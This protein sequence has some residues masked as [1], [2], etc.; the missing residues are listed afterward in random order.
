MPISTY[1]GVAGRNCLCLLTCESMDASAHG[2][3]GALAQHLMKR[4]LT[5]ERF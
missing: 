4:N 1:A 2:A 5:G 3:G